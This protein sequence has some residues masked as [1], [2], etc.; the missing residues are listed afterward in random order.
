[1]RS[2]RLISWRAPGRGDIMGAQNRLTSDLGGY[3]MSSHIIS[4]RGVSL[5]GVVLFACWT[6]C[7]QGTKEA[8]PPRTGSISGHV[9]INNKAAANIEI[10]AFGADSAN[11]RV[12]SAQTKTD[13]EGFYHLRGLTAGSYQIATFTP[14][15]IAAELDPQ[16]PFGFGTFNLS[17]TVLL[18]AGEDVAEI[19]LKLKRGGVI[20]GRVTDADEKPIVEE[21]VSLQPIVENGQ[22][23]PRPPLP[24]AM[25]YLTD[26]RGVYRIY[27]LAA[28]RYRVSVGQSS[29]TPG[30]VNS[31]NG[32]YEM[33][34]HPDTTDAS[35][36]RVVEVTE[37][38]EATNIDIK[39]GPRKETHSI[40][41]RVVDAENGLPIS[42][43]RIGVMVMREQAYTAGTF[44]ATSADGT[45]TLNG[46]TGGR[47]GIYVT[48]ENTEAD[49][50]SDPVPVT[51]TDEDV[52]G[53]E[54]KALHGVSISGT[55]VGDNMAL[56]DLMAQVGALRVSANV[57]PLDG[58]MTASTIRSSGGASVAPDGSFTITR[59]RP[60]RASPG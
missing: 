55:V 46:L 53:V 14:N 1:M 13:S 44:A 49:V 54:V 42:G 3:L 28:G 39:L 18:A 60:G 23:A 22:P 12:A 6:G 26:D 30:F 57:M 40:T 33:T 34:F 19:D 47:Y 29:A 35:R 41:G 45:F 32:F 52:S 25:M 15:M 38:G 48:S 27:G 36:A 21:R 10:G 50:Y 7:A 56:K 51:V 58:R 5:I 59:V 43:A 11:R 31:P 9:L 17:K 24:S 37:G 4:F 2:S 16:Y 8:N 20:T